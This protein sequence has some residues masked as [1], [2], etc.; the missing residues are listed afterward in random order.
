[1]TRDNPPRWE[2]QMHYRPLPPP[3]RQEWLPF[4]PFVIWGVIAWTF[5]AGVF[6]V[7]GFVV[8]SE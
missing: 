2:P 7:L 3:I 1:M 6:V 5:V 4:S 8:F